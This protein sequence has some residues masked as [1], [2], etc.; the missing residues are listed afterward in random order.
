MNCNKTQC[1]LPRCLARE[2][3]EHCDWEPQHLTN[4]HVKPFFQCD[5]FKGRSLVWFPRRKNAGPSI[6]RG[7]VVLLHWQKLV[8]LCLFPH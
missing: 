3:N 2:E 6:E 4:F 7:A 1:V 8:G 5:V